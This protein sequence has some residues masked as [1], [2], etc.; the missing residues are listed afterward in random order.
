[1][2]ILTGVGTPI[3]VRIMATGSSVITVM[4]NGR[5]D[6]VRTTEPVTVLGVQGPGQDH[7]KIDLIIRVL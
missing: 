4:D 1:M 7:S 6:P 2:F 5:T 3:A